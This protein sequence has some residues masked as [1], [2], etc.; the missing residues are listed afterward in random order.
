MSLNKTTRLPPSILLRSIFLFFL[1]LEAPKESSESVKLSIV[2][3]IFSGIQSS[4]FP[5]SA[6]GWAPRCGNTHRLKRMK[7][8][9]EFKGLLVDAS[10]WESIEHEGRSVEYLE[11]LPILSTLSCL[12][13]LVTTLGPA[14]VFVIAYGKSAR[15]EKNWL[16]YR[17]IWRLGLAKESVLLCRDPSAVGD[18]IKAKGVNVFFSADPTSSTAAA[19]TGNN[20]LFFRPEGSAYPVPSQFPSNV[21]QLALAP[22]APGQ[23]PQDPRWPLREQWGAAMIWLSQHGVGPNL[24]L[25]P[26]ESK[27]S[28]WLQLRTKERSSPSSSSSSSSSSSV[29]G[30]AKVRVVTPTP[31]APV[32]CC[33]GNSFVGLDLGGTGPEPLIST[34]SNDDAIEPEKVSLWRLLGAVVYG[35]DV[36]ASAAGSGIVYD[37]HRWTW[38]E[39]WGQLLHEDNTVAL[40]TVCGCRRE[41]EGEGERAGQ[42]DYYGEE[43]DADAALR[44]VKLRS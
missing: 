27:T 33:E 21:V 12:E 30:G 20:S 38:G 1:N 34:G 31:S 16:D 40:R 6:S 9:F 5:S 36:E 17:N 37:E 29:E 7:A 14:N 24:R 2:L 44:S 43:F 22:M 13:E 25:R 3:N 32:D 35:K 18:L 28:Q 11:A 15:R 23:P 39:L 26:F 19:M 41:V 8:A 10:E 4:E 42:Q